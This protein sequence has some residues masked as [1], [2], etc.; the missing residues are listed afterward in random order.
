MC[1]S[2][3]PRACCPAIAAA[4]ALV[5]AACAVPISGCSEET[6]VTGRSDAAS[7]SR[8]DAGLP[9]RDGS[10][11]VLTL[12]DA[13][14]EDASDDTGPPPPECSS[15]S[16]NTGLFGTV[17]DLATDGRSVWLSYVFEGQVQLA[18]LGADLPPAA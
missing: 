17:P 1:V 10:R 8:R 4:C 13:V 18:E 3:T 14:A 5:Q 16:V 12:L 7:S 9:A 11:D 2:R 6:P 15:I